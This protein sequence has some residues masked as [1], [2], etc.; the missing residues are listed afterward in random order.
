MTDSEQDTKLRQMG[1]ERGYV[2]PHVCAHADATLCVH[3]ET[4]PEI[5][6]YT[7]IAYQ[8]DRCGMVT[9]RDVTPDDMATPDLPPVDGEMWN[10]AIRAANGVKLET[11]LRFWQ[12]AI[13]A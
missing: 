3:T 2:R 6:T 11:T 8:C 1:I 4:D 13:R 10:Q 12:K 7:L 5:G 9:R